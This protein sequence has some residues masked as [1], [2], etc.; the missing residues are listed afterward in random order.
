MTVLQSI[1]AQFKQ[2]P[3]EVSPGPS[4]KEKDSDVEEKASAEVHIH[5]ADGDHAAGVAGIEAMQV[6]WG[7]KGRWI[8]IA[9][10]A[11]MMVIFEL[12]NSTVYNYQTFATSSFSS[13]S[14]LSAI[15]TAQ[16]LVSAVIKPVVAKLSD[17][18]GRG[19]SYLLTISCYI[20]SYILCASSA[21][22]DIYAGGAMFY[23]IGQS[24]TQVLDQIII[25]DISNQRWRG[26]AIGSSYF[27][28]LITPWVSAFIV[29]SVIG[30]IGWRWG[31]GMFAILMPFCASFII[32]TLIFFGRK[33][34]KTGLVV[35]KR[36]TIYDFCSLI[37]LG[38]MILL[39]GGFVMLLL[40]ICLAATTPSKWSTAYLDAL[41]GVGAVLLIALVP[42]ERFYAKHP[43][44]P[45]RYF[46]NMTIVMS[47]LLSAFDSIGLYAWCI[48]A[49]DYS[50]R[51]ATFLVYLNGVTQCLVGIGAGWLMY[52]T[53]HYKWLLV[54]GCTIRF[55]GYGVMMRLR[56]QD[57]TMAELFVVQAVQ[58]IG[59]GIV[60]T[61]VVVSAQI[62]VP[63]AELAQISS[64]VLLIG[65]L[66]SAVGQSIAGGIY[67]NT[68]PARLHA[69]LRTLTG[70]LPEWVNY[71]YSDVMRY[72]TIVALVVSVPIM[73]FGLLLPNRRLG[74]THNAA[75]GTDVAGRQIEN[76]SEKQ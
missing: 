31:I 53:R 71:A 3:S 7:T 55:V 24:G 75:E 45:L 50:V 39:L 27:P 61:I 28:F 33:A 25:A 54:V 44:V 69:R 1:A 17:V 41:I 21:T 42:Y 19:E 46:G 29:D 59:S 5:V 20:L 36:L 56:G 40:P 64:L 34:K 67:T 15:S 30:G 13:L 58:G 4:V 14:K 43:I 22:V 16:T 10:L 60:Q 74:D 66:G 70:V 8:L 37:D 65:F 57:N 76:A 12:D 18:I 26:F 6:V 63:H 47:C 48:V 62:V 51:N 38:G 49:H 23:A 32:I 68:F 52:K 35:K 2:L 11:L 9:G 73:I 72:I